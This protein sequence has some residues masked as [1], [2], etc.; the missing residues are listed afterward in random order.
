MVRA[1]L[2]GLREQA[3]I[4]RRDEEQDVKEQKTTEDQ[5]AQDVAV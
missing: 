2:T 5:L 4:N 1:P 3:T